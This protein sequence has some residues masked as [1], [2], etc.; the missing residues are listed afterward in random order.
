MKVYH[1]QAS[2]G[3]AG[4]APY[5]LHQ[6]MLRHGIDSYIITR[7]TPKKVNRVIQPKKTPGWFL[8]RVINFMLQTLRKR[9]KKNDTYVYNALPWIGDKEVV[10]LV[11]DA[12]VIYIHWIGGD[13]LSSENLKTIFRYGKP[14]IF[15]LHDMWTM[16]GGCHHAFDCNKYKDWCKQCPMFSFGGRIAHK[17][18]IYK[19]HLFS[20][21]NN[22]YFVTPSKWEKRCALESTVL[23]NLNIRYIPNYIDDKFFH[24]IDKRI[25]RDVLGLPQDKFII[26]FGCQN[27]TNNKF[28]GWIYLREAL[29]QTNFDDV[30]LVVFG[31]DYNQATVNELKYPVTFMGQLFDET[32]LVLLDN[33]ADLHVSPSLAESF[34]MTFVENALCGTPVV[35]FDGTAVPEIVNEYTGLLAKYK[36][37]EDLASC[38]T[39]IHDDGFMVTLREH[40]DS[41]EIFQKHQ[42]LMEEAC[43]IN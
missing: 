41:N 6:A 32:S 39:K 14:V 30:H 10:K 43:K 8:K 37:A 17:E 16:T 1:L 9:G 34:G 42:N 5:R 11:N 26:T 35:G 21:Y 23:H 27:G 28:K 4:N 7:N 18:A 12:D 2:M 13:F 22:I 40:Y 36:D 33:A 29:N 15:Y 25:A 19:Q 24:P 3:A 31:S 38:I 20:K